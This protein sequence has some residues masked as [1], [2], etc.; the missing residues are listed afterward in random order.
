MVF[1]LSSTLV[2]D[3]ARCCR[4]D[5]SH[6]WCTQGSQYSDALLGPRLESRTR[7]VS[8]ACHREELNRNQ[9]NYTRLGSPEIPMAVRI[10]W[11]THLISFW[12]LPF[13]VDDFDEIRLLFLYR[14]SR[15][16]RT[17]TTGSYFAWSGDAAALQLSGPIGAAASGLAAGTALSQEVHGTTPFASRGICAYVVHEWVPLHDWSRNRNF[18]RNA[19]NYSLQNSFSVHGIT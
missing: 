9:R 2:R 19:A 14:H 12:S 4:R 15:S 5:A 11:L 17:E 3:Y 10:C 7:S 6:D 18:A 1:Q 8:K 16:L 13:I